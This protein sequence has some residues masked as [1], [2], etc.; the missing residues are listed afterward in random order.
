MLKKIN[1]NTGLSGLNEAFDKIAD[2]NIAYFSV[3]GII[4]LLLSVLVMLLIFGILGKD[5][6]LLWVR[7]VM[8]MLMIQ[9]AFSFF[10][11]VYSTM[12]ISYWNILFKDSLKTAL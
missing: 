11:A 10:I 8:V 2:S 3:S 9:F 4:Q 5:R 7:F 12:Q 1:Y 6:Q